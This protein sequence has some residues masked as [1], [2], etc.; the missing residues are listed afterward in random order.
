MPEALGGQRISTADE[1]RVVQ[2]AAA[3]AVPALVSGRGVNAGGQPKSEEAAE[4][5]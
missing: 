2:I 4:R 1:N 5:G 3:H